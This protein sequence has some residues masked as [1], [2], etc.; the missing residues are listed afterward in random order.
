MYLKKKA[1]KFCNSECK[2][3]YYNVP[4][5]CDNCKKD[6]MTKI[7]MIERVKNGKRK[8]LYCP[9]CTNNGNGSSYITKVCEFCK[10]NFKIQRS[11]RNQR[12][13]SR[14]C[15]SEGKKKYELRFCET[16]DKSFYPKH[17]EQKFCSNE[18]KF[19]SKKNRISCICHYCGK[20]IEKKYSDYEKCNFNYCSKDCF[21]LDVFW[22]DDE[23]KILME[24]YGKISNN[25]ISIL[26]NNKYSGEAIKSKALR[27]GLGNK[28]YFWTKEEEQILKDNYS[29]IPMKEL[30][31]LLPNRSRFSIIGKA[32]TFNIFSYHYLTNRYSS[33]EENFLIKNYLNMSNMELSECLGRSEN[34]I[35]QHLWCL[36]LKRPDEGRKYDNLAELIRKRLRPWT[37]KIKKDN[38]YTCCLTGKKNGVVLHHC[39]GFNL[40]LIEAIDDLNF[41][42]KD[43]I[44]DYTK[45]DIKEFVD[46]MI[47]LHEY[48]KEYCC[49]TAEI[50]KLFH[51]IYGYGN[52][53]IQQW[54]EFVHD[55]KNNVYKLSA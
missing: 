54:N 28:E 17:N 53:N 47:Y 33:D 37:N 1:K 43:N 51:S 46:Y 18:C 7:C 19:E 30:L 25:Q 27:L 16:C 40:L 39:R 3:K 20:I 15:E 49:V 29:E 14:K 41:N 48:Y 26:L 4:Y 38:N 35:S 45:E 22:S 10:N 24:N 32:K 42:V 52:N 12:Y 21:H 34:A 55:Y 9:D 2:D 44:D 6:F 13:C 23:E 36:G 11:L 50:H 8:H 5:T 31:I